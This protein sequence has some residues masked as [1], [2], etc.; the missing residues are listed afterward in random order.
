MRVMT[1]QAIR[2]LTSLLPLCGQGDSCVGQLRRRT[3]RTHTQLIAL[4]QVDRSQLL[5]LQ[6]IDGVCSLFLSLPWSA[7]LCG[8]GRA[9]HP[10]YYQLTCP[11]AVAELWTATADTADHQVQLV[12]S[13]ACIQY[14]PSK[15]TYDL[16]VGKRCYTT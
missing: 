11:M 7:S 1:C 2:G 15:T 12:N 3:H 4:R 8:E 10:Q 13:Q 14:K 6:S 16:Y 5:P 9:I